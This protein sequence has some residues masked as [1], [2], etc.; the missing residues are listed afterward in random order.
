MR[1]GA[2]TLKTGLAVTITLFIC[3]IFNIEPASFAAITA[4]VNMQPSVGKSLKNAWEQIGVHVLAVVVSLIIGSLLGTSPAIIGLAVVIIILLCNRIGWSGG[5]ILGIVSIIFILDSPPD[6]FLTHALNRS[7]S[8]FAGLG[9]ALV[10]NRIL[11]PPRYKAKFLSQLDELFLLSA[12]YFLDSL[13]AF[14]HAGNLVSYDKPDPLE[15]KEAL[16]KVMSLYE[17]A[18]DELIAE[19]NRLFLERL[20]EIC[21]GFIERGQNINAV[22]AQ[23]VKRRQSS[24]APFNIGQVTQEFQGVLDVLATGE[25]TLLELIDTLSQGLRQKK[26]FGFFGEDV[27]YWERFDKIFDDWN[28][29]VSG[30]F[31]L[32]ALMEVSVVATEV[33]WAARRTKTLLNLLDKQYSPNHNI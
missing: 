33:R 12:R 6:Q 23:R 31:Y 29:Q 4:V 9:V 21:S 5:I 1:I 11:A 24:D 18:R 30:V 20:L 3:K 16:D 2:R 19:D 14:I 15:Q 32:R 22:T 26:S 17:Y 27:L 10:I 8:I 25:T 13:H 7:L 28:R